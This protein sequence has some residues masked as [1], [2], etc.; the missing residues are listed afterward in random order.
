M[1]Y[2]DF[3]WDGVQTALGLTSQRL[4][5]FPH[6]VPQPV[7]PWLQLML[8]KSEQFAVSEKARSEFFVAPLLFA[9]RE[10]SHERF[11]IHSGERL[12]VEPENGLVGE[13]DFL[14]SLAPPMPVVQVPIVVI[15]EAKRGIIEDGL[16]QCAAQMVGSQRFNRKRGR[17]I[18]PIFGC[19]T[20]GEVWQF[21]R[22]D[23]ANLALDLSRY[24]IKTPGLLLGIFHTIIASY[25]EEAAAA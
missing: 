12:D 19:V 3:T 23:G 25:P 16:G 13:C 7:S 5:L 22:L 8:D 10:L 4:N 20:T 18:T 24:S 17:E 15:L 21:L 2:S 6:V 1:A 11:A 14:L 9:S